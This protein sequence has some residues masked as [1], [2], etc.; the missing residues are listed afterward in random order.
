MFGAQTPHGK[1]FAL[2]V[3]GMAGDDEIGFEILGGGCQ[4]VITSLAGR[5]HDAGF[6]LVALPDQDGVRNAERCAEVS[7]LARLVCGAGAQ[8]MIDGRGAKG[9]LE[10]GRGLYG[11]I[12]KKKQAGGIAA[13]RDR[14]K[15]ARGALKRGEK[16]EYRLLRR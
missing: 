11:F 6:G 15:D 10:I 5:S 7:D 1:R 8:R 16:L 3:E 9:N 13:A 12:E 4:Q 14:D 2:V